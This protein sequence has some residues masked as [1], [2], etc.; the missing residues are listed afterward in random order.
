M[1]K[2]NSFGNKLLMQVL[3][4]VILSL[5]IT[6]FF[7]SKYSYETAQDDAQKYIQQLAGKYAAD[8]ENNLNQSLV[9]SKTLGSKFEESLN[10]GVKMNEKET[11]AYFKSLLKYNKEVI[12]I[13]FKNK[14][15][16]LLF[17]VKPEQAG[18]GAYDKTGQFN[19][20][21]VRSKGSII[22]QSGS[23]YSEDL[24]WIAGPMNS[25]KDYITKPY[26]YPVDGVDVLMTTIA[27]P[28]YH[29]GEFFGSIGMDISLDTFA[30]TA[31]EA[32]VYE[33][34]YPFIVDHFGMIVGHPNK[35]VIGKELMT[36]I[37]GDPDYQRILDN[38][39][40]GKDT[41]FFK[42]SYKDGLESYYYTKSFEIGESGI[43]W[44]F[45]LTAP[46]EEYLSHA[47]FVRNFSIIALLIALIIIGGVITLSVRKLNGNL[48]KITL[49]LDDF[50]EYL[51]TKASNPKEIVLNSTDEFGVMAHSI[52]ENVKMIQEGISKDNNLIE[53]VKS[54]V[55]HVG[56]GHLDKRIDSTT[57]TK[58][59]DELKNLLNDMLNNLES[60]V[61]KD[62]NK[63]TQ[64]LESYT[65]RDFTAKLDSSSAGKIGNEI[66][67]MNSMITHMLQDSQKDATSLQ[68]SSSE[69]TS[70]VKVLS[71][72]ATSQASSLEET[73]A[74]IDEITSNIEQTSQKAQE[75][76]VISNET[77]SSADEGK[78]MANK[79]VES[80]DE[81]NNTVIAINDAI[82]VIDQIAFQTNILSLNAAVEA[83]TAGEAGKGFA[84][85]AAEVRN[86]ASR[87]AEAAKEIKDL[88]ESATVKAD[89]GKKIS[90]K[91]IE[92]FTQLEQKIMDTSVLIDDVATAA[93]EQ[94][95]GMTQIS[96]AVGQLDKFT[97]EN[98]NVADRTNSIAQETN[99]IATQVAM[100]VQKNDFDNKQQMQAAPKA[101]VAY[102][103]PVKKEAVRST[104]PT[105]IKEESNDDSWESF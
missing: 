60:L 39:K 79:T 77:K 84:V 34:G 23:T 45:V 58:S 99:T 96:D 22:V 90:S 44:S 28:M 27:I 56:Q 1:K 53:S 15:A 24:E 17:D 21:V 102:T 51:N 62:I 61:G 20:Y 73:A 32:K 40:Q 91:M 101:K 104:K 42:N 103:S 8:L 25:R 98:A 4:V 26:L 65:K 37:K 38:T 6:I 52:N 70:N 88:V 55:N 3:G 63:I 49:G 95:Q 68:T 47:N 36:V 93:K 31:S 54:I 50:F 69:L 74:S 10:T 86:L 59:L 105:P 83:A 13:W 14:P 12:G 92:G 5:G 18:K 81:I 16:D 97:Q 89:D 43:H 29:N 41:F 9:V 2:K 11:I 30:K 64:I 94:T 87:S 66:I 33:N 75:M 80:M 67:E 48:E 46:T 35:E 71:N 82:S 57:S 76:A 7:V 85:V 19:P 100:N 72:N 78:T